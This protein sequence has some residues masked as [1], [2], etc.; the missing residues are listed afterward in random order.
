MRDLVPICVIPEPICR[1]VLSERGERRQSPGCGDPDSD[2]LLVPQL[3]RERALSDQVG[4]T[5]LGREREDTSD[6][7]VRQLREL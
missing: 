4:A 2:R 5:G 7:L 1:D 6:I 3:G